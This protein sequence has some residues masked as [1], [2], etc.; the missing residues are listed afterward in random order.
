MPCMDTKLHITMLH[1][2]MTGVLATPMLS[3]CTRQTIRP[4]MITA[5]HIHHITVDTTNT[6][7]LSILT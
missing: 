6:P 1:T 3:Q 7:M 5:M 4:S 2:T